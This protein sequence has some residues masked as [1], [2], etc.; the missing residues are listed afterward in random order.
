MT[1]TRKRTKKERTKKE[2][3][4]KERTKKGGAF[5]TKVS[6]V[7]PLP[8]NAISVPKLT[9][10]YI[11]SEMERLCR[12]YPTKYQSANKTVRC[13]KPRSP[14]KVRYELVTDLNYILKEGKTY[15]PV[16]YDGASLV[17]QDGKEWMVNGKQK[18]KLYVSKADYDRRVARLDKMGV[19]HISRFGEM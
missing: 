3:T 19:S 12:Q 17:S 18:Y 5:A 16:V 10:S 14:S 11:D 9:Q 15:T 13:D 1:K 8:E 2:R 7:I 4:K 6:A